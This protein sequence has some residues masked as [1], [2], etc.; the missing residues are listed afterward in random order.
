MSMGTWLLVLGTDMLGNAMNAPL[1]FIAVVLSA[2]ATSVPDTIISMK[3]AR[4]GNFDDAVSNAL[5]SNIFDIA[6][7]L[8]LPI[9]LYNLFYDGNITLPDEIQDF[10]QE[11]WVFLLMA[12]VFALGVM[13]VGKYFNR[14]KAYIL[15]A[16]Y[17][18]VLLFVGTQVHAGFLGGIGEPIGDFLTQIADWIGKAF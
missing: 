7:A 15:L 2:V 3:D 16:I 17:A 4:K 1:I 12:T 14:T 9:L 5:G 18:L 11:V 13:L 10:T 8:G 6:F